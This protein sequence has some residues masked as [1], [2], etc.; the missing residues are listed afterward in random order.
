MAIIFFVLLISLQASAQNEVAIGSSTTKSNAILWLN[1]NGS[2]GLILPVVTNKSAVSNPDKGMV[3]FDDSDDK[4]Y[5]HSG[6]N[7]VEVGGGGGATSNPSL[8]L[9]GNQLQLKDGT[10]VKSTVNL[11]AGTQSNGAFLVFTGGSWQYATL[12]GDVTGANGAIQVNGVKGKTIPTLPTTTQALV[13]DGTAWKFQAITAGTDSQTLTFTSPNLSI[14]NGNS[15]NLSTLDKDAQTLTLTGN[16]LSISG[17]NAVTLP[18]GTLTSVT[19]GTG[20][21][22]G[23]ITNTGT[24]NVDVGTTANKIVQLDATGKLPAVDGSQLTNLAGDISAI[25]AGTGLTGGATTGAATLNVDVGTTANKIV[26]L[27]ATGKLPAVDGSQLTNLASATIAD[28]SITGGSAGAGVKIAA[29]TITDANIL[30]LNAGKITSGTLPLAQVPNLDASKITTGTFTTAQIPNLDASKITSGVLPTT[31]GGTGISFSSGSIGNGQLLIGNSGSFAKANLT[32]GT[33]INITNGTGTIAIATTGDFGSQNLTTSGTLIAGATTLSALTINGAVWPANASGVLTNNGSGTLTWTPTGGTGTVT[34]VGLAMPSIFT[35]TNSPI[36]T[37]GTLT[38][39]LASQ[40]AA[41]VFAAPSGSAGVPTFRGLLSS[42]IPNLDASKITTGNLAIANGGTGSTTPA[43][44]L[45]NLGALSSTASA[46]GDLT[47]TFSNLQLV[48]NS[49]TNTDISPTAAILGTKIDPSFGGLNVSTTGTLTAGAT[50]LTSL[51]VPGTTSFNSRLYTWP[52]TAAA[53]NTYLRNDGSGNLSWTTVAAA[54]D[55]TA[56]NGILQGNGTAITGLAATTGLQ[57]LR[58]NSGNTAFEFATLS[59]SDIPNLD[60]TK[61]T[62]GILPV[63]VGGTGRSTWNGLLLGSGST[64]SDISTGTAGQ[65]LK[66]V[67]T[68]PSWGLITDAN[69]DPAAAINGSKVIPNF[70]TQALTSGT[71]TTFGTLSYTWPGT[72]GAAN[73]VLTN[74]G[75]GNLTWAGGIG[76][77]LTG[78]TGTNPATNFIGTTDVQPLIFKVNNDFSGKIEYGNNANTLLGWKAGNV[79]TG[80][81]NVALGKQAL[82]SNTSGG[83]NTSVGSFSLNANTSGFGNTAIGADAL[84]INSS[85]N[86]NTAVGRQAGVLIDGLSNATAI[87]Y[88]A[89]VGASNALVLGGTG[90]D[91]VNVG[92]GT[93]SPISKLDV[94]GDLRLA[95]ITAPSTTTD[96]LYNVGG[97]LFWNGTNISSG[98]SGWGLTGNSSTVDGTNF[99]GTTDNIPFT[100]RVNNQR[101]IRISFTNATSAPN[102]LAGYSGNTITNGVVGSAIL[103]GG[104]DVQINQVTDNYSVIGGGSLNQAGDNDADLANASA[105]TVSGG[106]LN[107]ATSSF[108]TVGGGYNNQASG[109]SAVV[110]GG[111]NAT[112]SGEAAGVLSGEANIAS[113]YRSAVVGGNASTASGSNSFVGGGEFNNASGVLSAVSGGVS[114][115]ASGNITSIPGGQ[116]LFAR[117]FGETSVGI[118]NADYT[119]ASTTGF[120]ANDRLFVIGNGTSTSSRSNALTVLK[121]GKVGIGTTSPNA[122]LQFSNSVGRKIVLFEQANNDNEF[123]GFAVG[124]LG[125]FESQI[126]VNSNSFVWKTATSSTSSNELMRITGTGNVGI[127]TTTPAAKLDIAGTIKITDGTQAAGK[128]LTSDANGLA[129]WQTVGSSTGWTLAG[130][131]VSSSD[132]IGTINNLPFNIKVNSVV[133]GTINPTSNNTFFGYGGGKSNPTGTKNSGFGDSALDSNTSGNNNAGFGFNTLTNNLAGSD[134][135]AFGYQ[136]MNSNTNAG[137]N[138]ALG[139]SALFSLAFAN[140]TTAYD[141]WNTGVGYQALYNTNPT[142]TSNGIFNTALG[143]NAGNA[144]TTGDKNTFLG[145]SAGPVT[146]TL[147]NA[148]AIGYNAQ[149]SASNSLVLG[150]TG[151]DAVKVGVGT[152]A[153]NFLLQ[154][155][156][157]SNTQAALQL[158]AGTATGSTLTDGLIISSNGTAA[159]ILNRDA[160]SLNLGTSAATRLTITSTGNIGLGNATPNAPVQLATTTANRK[161]VL[162]DVNNDDHQFYGFGVQ[163]GEIRYQTQSTL[164]N[165][166]FY[167]GTS[168]TTSALLMTISGA[169]NV[170]ITGSLSKGSGT[171]K[172][173]H[174]L[175]PENKFLYHSFVESPDMMNVYNGNVQTDADGNVVVTLPEY[176]E[177]L[178]KDFRYQLT[179]IGQFAQAIVMEELK[180]NKFSIKT[181]KPNVKVSWQVTGIRKDPFAEKN[182]VVPE[183]EKAADEKGKYLHPEA[184][185]QPIEKKIG[186]ENP[187]LKQD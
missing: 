46:G 37:S 169:G 152:T 32:S 39:T 161:L 106:N 63:S 179:V 186:Y 96:K 181:D 182:R 17:G 105:A 12:S 149:V 75:A 118:F 84:S 21:T 47:G 151:S 43:G 14:S 185:G 183:V 165:H 177:A 18:A 64:I 27:D 55:L 112:A 130:N 8:L 140:G 4:V 117:S 35:V 73:S 40:T 132:F 57:Y 65:V 60:A 176:F 155:N 62:S 134:N 175:D 180:E 145:A 91:A 76:W 119:P 166:R 86:Y 153:P 53:A 147:S 22:G 99:I 42:D 114:N 1:G 31:Q 38:T 131:T 184:Y 126:P 116:G 187:E 163:S 162:Y 82:E 146:G 61:I 142:S 51:V 67:G 167:A 129:S 100:I 56:Q 168:S 164:S 25:T 29:N 44:A 49:I 102:I 139:R 85:G 79:N 26:Q 158:T 24:I 170:A 157:V 97:S 69:I 5:Y 144:N 78:N 137:S 92:I 107:K 135:T 173:D 109:N 80:N 103:S 95:Q 36:T 136:A 133:S 174:P 148:T 50:T 83:I 111:R 3:V 68:S 2:Q 71:S 104:S 72:A 127:G 52:N 156:D 143:Y 16:S 87:G 120:D 108:A 66:V 122:Q 48:T 178:N 172:I 141:S 94:A 160:T 34:S 6:A 59:S 89:K 113:G 90:V 74:D 77:G 7:W 23:T 154:L 123:I 81:N 121:S 124:G 138:T 54:T 9:E 19:A 15:V 70:G 88:N 128:V 41:T 10:T 30:S 150:G 125:T 11:A 20:L 171:F 110:A 45:T 93:T 58:R 159:N 101:A 115:L 98:G 13:Y 33:G 28:G